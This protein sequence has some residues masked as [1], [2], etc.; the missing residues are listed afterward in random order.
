MSYI[1]TL[2]IFFSVILSFS[3]FIALD[4]SLRVQEWEGLGNKERIKFWG[5]VGDV[6]FKIS[7]TSLVLSL[8]LNL[9]HE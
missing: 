8:V 2:M 7:M 4:S 9:F 5:G 3:V 6:G 1:N